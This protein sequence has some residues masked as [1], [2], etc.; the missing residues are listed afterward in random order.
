MNNL[1]DREIVDL[2]LEKS[3]LFKIPSPFQTNDDDDSMS[4]GHT[5][6]GMGGIL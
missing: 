6:G 3:H 2:D 1:S 5:T 4:T